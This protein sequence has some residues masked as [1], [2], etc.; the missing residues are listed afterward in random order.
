MT[1]QGDEPLKDL[2]RQSYGSTVSSL[3]KLHSLEL[4]LEVADAIG[5]LDPWRELVGELRQAVGPSQ[6]TY[7]VKESEGEIGFELYW[8]REPDSD[9]VA[10]DELFA[11]VSSCFDV[12]IDL[13]PPVDAVGM[14][15]VPRI[16]EAVFEP[17]TS[18]DIY[19]LHGEGADSPGTVQ[20]LDRDGLHPKSGY[21]FYGQPAGFGQV[22]DHLTR[23][24][25]TDGS[26]EVAMGLLPDGLASCAIIGVV[27]KPTTTG[28]IFHD[29][30]IRQFLTFLDNS[31][32]PASLTEYV[33][34]NVELF[35]HLRFDVELDYAAVMGKARVMRSS[36]FGS[37]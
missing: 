33:D 18:L 6:T 13:E 37:I 28:V 10:W 20:T 30:D 9:A 3:G 26:S 27:S 11:R 23:L 14:S 31:S 32:I 22:L 29:I 35:D 25:M 8:W 12:R 19:H 4:L 24:E 7:T 21:R 16:P 34:T 15:L 2:H 1:I 36:F 17:I 5:K